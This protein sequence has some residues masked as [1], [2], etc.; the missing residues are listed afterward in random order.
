MTYVDT[1][2]LAAS[3]CQE[4]LSD[5]AQRA[6][7]ETGERAISSLVE[8]E[9]A[10]ALARK[11]R[12]R[13][14]RRA[15]AHRILAVFQAHLEQGIYARLAVDTAHYAKAREWMATFTFSLHTLDALHLAVA[16]M[17]DCS[18][19]TADTT[20]AKACAKVGVPARLIH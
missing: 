16:A 4:P 8:V 6:L 11:V 5:Q 20:L 18:F 2:V 14:M 17:E 7:A 10:S 3:Y 1:S 9:L 13:E 19:L 12:S 15:D